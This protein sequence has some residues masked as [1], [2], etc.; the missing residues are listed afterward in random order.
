MGEVVKVS[1]MVGIG[2][3]LSLLL[4]FYHYLSSSIYIRYNEILI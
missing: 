3:Q 4:Y 1:E 2:R